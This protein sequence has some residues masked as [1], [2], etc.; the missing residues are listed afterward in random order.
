MLNK[1]MLIGNLGRDPELQVTGTGKPFSRFSLAV[2]QGGKD[3]DGLKKL[4]RLLSGP[5]L[6]VTLRPAN[7]LPMVIRKRTKVCRRH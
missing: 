1:I 4:L 2:D 7:G 3:K 5:T 6:Q